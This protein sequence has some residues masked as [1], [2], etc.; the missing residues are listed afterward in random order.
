MF[1]F[2]HKPLY[3]KHKTSNNAEPRHMAVVYFFNI[4]FLFVFKL[5]FKFFAIVNDTLSSLKLIFVF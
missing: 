5:I 1:M 2:I 3:T 4:V